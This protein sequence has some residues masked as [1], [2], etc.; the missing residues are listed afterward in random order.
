MHMHG[1]AGEWGLGFQLSQEGRT[2][3]QFCEAI[4]AGFDDPLKV[5][6]EGE[7]HRLFQ[8]GSV[9][10]YRSSFDKLRFM[11]SQD[12]PELKERFF[13]NTYISGLREE[14]QNLVLL[15]KPKTLA[16]AYQSSI[17]QESI[18]ESLIKKSRRATT[19]VAKPQVTGV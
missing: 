11:L 12:N 5:G 8:K 15:N 10:E 19:I 1:E 3:Y 2:W 4:L 14:L 9:S 18:W 16:S 13:I 17:V 6:V 7:F